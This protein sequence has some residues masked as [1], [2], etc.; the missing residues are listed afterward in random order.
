M[1]GRCKP[2]IIM[3]ISN[4]IN[5]L[6]GSVARCW[7]SVS[8]PGSNKGS[9]WVLMLRAWGVGDGGAVLWAM[10]DSCF[11]PCSSPFRFVWV[12]LWM[13]WCP[14]APSCYCF[15][16]NVVS[17]GW[18]PEFYLT[19]NY[20]LSSTRASTCS[21]DNHSSTHGSW[22]MFLVW[23]PTL[24]YPPIIF[25]SEHFRFVWWQYPRPSQSSDSISFK[26]YLSCIF[27]FFFNFKP[28]SC[29]SAPLK[30]MPFRY[31]F[32]QTCCRARIL[33]DWFPW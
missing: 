28:R 32:W 18:M 15:G 10:W 13:W 2:Q 27:F 17:A 1:P 19:A 5:C 31:S 3:T 33:F 7:K 29:S 26:S 12:A 21:Y 30:K 16:L 20:S 4:K 6:C 25:A 22:H 8:A 14:F 9:M 23:K 11:T 24:L